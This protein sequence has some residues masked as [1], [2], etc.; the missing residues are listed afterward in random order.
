MSEFPM[1]PAEN[2]LFVPKL[3]A[4]LNRVPPAEKLPEPGCG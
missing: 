3:P 1:N 2:R 4:L